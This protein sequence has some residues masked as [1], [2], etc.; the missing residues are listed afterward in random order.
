MPARTAKTRKMS[1]MYGIYETD[2]F[3][4]ESMWLNCLCMSWYHPASA[5]ESRRRDLMPTRPF[6]KRN[7]IRL[8]ASRDGR[9]FYYVGDR[10]PFIDLGSEDSWKPHYLRMANVDTVG[11]PL[12]KDDELWFY[13]IGQN[14]DGSKGT[15]QQKSGLAILRRD[16]FASL[17]AGEEAGIVITRPLVFEGEG[18]LF[19]NADVGTNGYVRVSVVAEDGSAIEGFGDEDCRAVCEDST[20]SRVGWGSNETLARLKDRYVRL[21]FHLTNAKLYSF[22]IE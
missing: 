15:W 7:L 6:V 22:W 11:G 3:P 14:T 2:G 9:H 5:E 19:V 10:S 16:G 21:A 17:N 4:Y 13:Y 8:G 18:K 12:V 1:G 20:R